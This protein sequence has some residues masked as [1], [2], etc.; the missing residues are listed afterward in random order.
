MSKSKRKLRGE[1][2][3]IKAE[4][5]IMQRQAGSAF[6]K[7]YKVGDE[8]IFER[9]TMRQPAMAEILSVSACGDDYRLKIRNRATGKEYWIRDYY[10]LKA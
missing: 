5:D 2:R 10:L 9:G 8:I 1:F 4:A 3:R 6:Y 7:A